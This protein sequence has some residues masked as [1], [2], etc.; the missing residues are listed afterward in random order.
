MNHDVAPPTM[1]ASGQKIRGIVDL[2]LE[3]G[4][5]VRVNVMPRVS[6][7]RLPGPLALSGYATRCRL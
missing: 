3:F 1:T 2:G 6:G 4:V 7:P 5:G